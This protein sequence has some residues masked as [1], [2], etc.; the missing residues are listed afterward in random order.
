V[1]S[2]ERRNEDEQRG[3]GFYRSERSYGRFQR[4]I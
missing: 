1:I 2:G 3:E 4:V